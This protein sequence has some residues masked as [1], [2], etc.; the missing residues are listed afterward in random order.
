MTTEI[1]AAA[2][3]GAPTLARAI[4]PKL[5]LFV[6]I[7][8]MLGTGIYALTGDV[9]GQ[10]G[11]AAWLAFG[12]AFIVALFTATSYLELVG[13][14]PRAAGAALYVHH[15]F[16]SR[17]ITFLVA[18][19]VMCSGLTSVAAASRTFAGY[20]Q[21]IYALPLL[22]LVPVFVIGLASINLRGVEESVKLNVV[23]TCIE[24]S[25]LL[26]VIAVGAFALSQG[27]GDAGKALEFNTG[28][29]P[30]SLVVSGAALA[31]FAIVGFE[32]SVNLVEETRDPQKNFP[33][34]FFIG[35]TITGVVYMLVAFCT[36][37]LVPIDTLRDSNQDLLEVVRIGAPW[38][39]LALFSFIAMVAV[40]NTSLINLMMASRLLYGM[41][42]EGV[43]PPV[44]GKVHAR[45]RTPWIAIVCT[46]VVALLLAS[47]SGVRTLGG[48]TALMLLC[49][50]ALVNVAVLVLRRRRVEHAHY[51][52]PTICPVLGFVSCT[53]LASPWA[54]RDPAQYEIAGVLLLV[55]LALFAL[56][57]W[58]H[59]RRVAARG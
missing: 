40:G 18:F 28:A 49:V 2:T 23:M 26:I 9:A 17:F 4:G 42:R 33:R 35:I 50:F 16:D 6:V 13:K 19:A 55:G 41:S 14:Y 53:Y 27:V 21:E 25:G 32:D 44:L 3:T 7:G 39:P 36:T 38:F 52:A 46:T 43:L 59:G 47:W 29:D 37:A 1:T 24:L 8:D 10:V 12:G 54:G 30:F 20:F 11:G 5:L 57:W 48:T 22:L 56:N 51:R 15:A 58:L 31:F 34:A 45:W